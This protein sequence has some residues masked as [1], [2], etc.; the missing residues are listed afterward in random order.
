MPRNKQLLAEIGNGMSI[1][2]GLPTLSSWN[3]RSRPKKPQNG[4][5]GFNQQ[6]NSLEY[7]NG[8]NWFTA[9]MA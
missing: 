6:T 7:W 1:M 4:T 5:I 2:L 3:T 8:K 9:Q